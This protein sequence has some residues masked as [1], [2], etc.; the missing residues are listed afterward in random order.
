MATPADTSWKRTF[1]A[2]FAAQGLAIVGFSIAMPFMAFYLR[3]LGVRSPEG[4]RRWSG[5]VMAGPPLTMVVFAPIWGAVAD[6]F[7]RRPMVM[8]AMFG[9]SVVLTL[10]AF[11]Q[12]PG[13]LLACRILQGALTGTITAMLAL[14]AS[15][16]PRERSGY[17]LGMMQAA[18]AFGFAMGPFIG[19][20]IAHLVG[21]RWGTIVGYRC[22]FIA[23]GVFLAVGGLLVL[24]FAREKFSRSEAREQSDGVTFKDVLTARGFFVAAF[25]LFTLR[26]AN[27]AVRPVFALFV[28][29]VHG[30]EGGASRIV[31]NILAAGGLAAM[32]GAFYFSR[33]SDRL[34][35]RRLLLLSC[36]VGGLGSFIYLLARTVSH[37]L[38]LRVAISFGAAGMRP[39]GNAIIRRC[40]DDRNMGKAFGVSASLSAIGWGL[41]SL[42]G[43]ELSARFGLGA[44]FV[45]MGLLLLLAGGLVFRFITPGPQ[46][47]ADGMP[48]A[49]DGI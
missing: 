12:T 6:R 40:T 49:N 23:A 35:H 48:G 11:A 33:K 19:G 29:D 26:F 46:G 38:L 25:A 21:T 7:G 9:G 13:Q 37:V 5:Y 44:P 45:L 8:R 3:E 16:A 39:A 32:L 17:A 47:A 18:V 22:T 30:S 20:H 1:Y 43:G 27:S 42:S 14:V 15:V 10:M 2:C 34:G 4:L 36:V 28:E 24:L 31:G 41:G